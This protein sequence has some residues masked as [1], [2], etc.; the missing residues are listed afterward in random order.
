MNHWLPPHLDHYWRN[1]IAPTVSKVQRKVYGA[2]AIHYQ[3]LQQEA[4]LIVVRHHERW[5]AEARDLY[6]YAKA[7]LFRRLANAARAMLRAQGDH[8]KL[9]GEWAK[10]APSYDPSVRGRKLDY[11]G[12]VYDPEPPDYPRNEYD[13]DDIAG[14]YGR[15]P[16]WA[17]T[18]AQTFPEAAEAFMRIAD[19]PKPPTLSVAEHGRRQDAARARLRAKHAAEIAAVDALED[20]RLMRAIFGRAA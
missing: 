17:R 13:P 9:G 15:S 14:V 12:N 10:L 18:F 1:V 7:E 19:R 8:G 5:E 3:D 16:R 4:R 6:P 2:Q 11:D 20:G